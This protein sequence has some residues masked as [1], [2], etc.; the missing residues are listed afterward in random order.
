MKSF[1]NI[2]PWKSIV[3]ALRSGRWDFETLKVAAS[4]ESGVCKIRDERVL[5]TITALDM[6]RE[7]VEKLGSSIVDYRDLELWPR[8]KKYDKSYG[9]P[10]K[11]TRALPVGRRGIEKVTTLCLHIP[12]VDLHYKRWLGVP[13]HGAIS[14]GK[15]IDDGMPRVVLCHYTEQYMSAAHSYNSFSESLEVGGFEDIHIQLAR[16]YVLYFKN[17]REQAGY[18]KHY[19]GTHRFAHKSRPVDCGKRIWEAVGEWAIKNHGFLLGPVVGSGKPL[20]FRENS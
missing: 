15:K 16:A 4:K 19:I 9:Y 5:G 14:S 12:G 18:N 7:D 1:L 11:K 10:L 2:S 17:K 3:A 8:D 6:L 13:V 20:P